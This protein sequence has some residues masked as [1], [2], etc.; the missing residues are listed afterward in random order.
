MTFIPHP[1]RRH[2]ELRWDYDCKNIPVNVNLGACH[3]DNVSKEVRD[4][5]NIVIGTGKPFHGHLNLII[6][7]PIV[8]K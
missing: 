3:Y 1:T 2:Q 4:C 8:K 5:F 7:T 6:V